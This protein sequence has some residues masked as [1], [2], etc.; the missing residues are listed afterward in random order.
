MTPPQAHPIRARRARPI[1]V[2]LL[3]AGSI[4]TGSFFATSASAQDDLEALEAAARAGRNDASAQTAYGHALLRA[5]RFSDAERVLRQ[6]AR[7]Q[8][9]SLASLYDLARVAF[10]QNDYRKSRAACRLLEREERRAALTHI[11]RARAFLVWNRAGRAFEELES[12][13]SI[14]GSDYELQLAFGDAH[15]LRAST[16]EAETAYRA[17]IA[18]DGSRAEPWLGLG[19]LY[20]QTSR[21]DDARTALREAR[22][23]DAND[24]QIAFELGRLLRGAE[25]RRLL[26]IAV[27]G[28]PEHVDAQVALGDLALSEGDMAAAR[29]AFEAALERTDEDPAAHAGMGRVLLAAGE[30]EA[31]E[32]RF[33]RALEIVPNVP[34]IVRT[35]GTLYEA[36]GRTQDAFA[37]YRHAHDLDPRNP[38]SLLAAARLALSQNR[39]VLATGFLDRLLQRHD[40][41]AAAL[42]LYGDALRAR[43]DRPGA[44]RY[45]R[46]ALEGTGPVD[47]AAVQAG[48]QA[49]SQTRS[50]G[51]VR[52]ATAP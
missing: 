5:E 48:I 26:E 38:A 12:A 25:A 28:R 29:S 49:A 31:A 41:L 45:Y 30:H 47:R 21:D 46:R 52:S 51:N 16:R 42:A 34:N 27:A 40:G 2:A 32:A 39:D 11:C 4:L 33:Q 10:A 23:R 43:G 14:G 3:F 9:N 50:R 22:T 13:Q 1:F 15:R 18:Q 7:L 35:L 17:A 19:L 8:D 24:P 20:S 37:Q 44:I 6:A 36:Q